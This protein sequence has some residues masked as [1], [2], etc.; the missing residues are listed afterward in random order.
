MHYDCVILIL[1]STDVGQSGIDKPLN[2]D[3]TMEDQYLGQPLFNH[4]LHLLTLSLLHPSMPRNQKNCEAIAET[5][6][7]LAPSFSLID[8]SSSSDSSDQMQDLD[9]DPRSVDSLFT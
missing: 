1:Y 9:Q 4:S 2:F 6:S 3:D 7:P 8:D 5:S